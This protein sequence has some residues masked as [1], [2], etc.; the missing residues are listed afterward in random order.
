MTN[1]NCSQIIENFPIGFIYLKTFYNEENKP[2]DFVVNGVNNEFEQL[3]NI[4]RKKIINK[5]LSETEKITPFSQSEFIP[6]LLKLDESSDKFVYNKYNLK[7]NKWLKISVYHA[8]K[9]EV[10][11]FFSDIT[12]SIQ[13]F[14]DASILF[15]IASDLFAISDLSGQYLQVNQ[16][17]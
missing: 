14:T 3:F 8:N 15:N 7:L 9:D 4:D 2:I 17:S 13:P 12:Q 5:R 16:I 10:A 6:K 11:I 1:Q